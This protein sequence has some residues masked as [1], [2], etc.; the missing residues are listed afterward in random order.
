MGKG[1][2]NQTSSAGD[3]QALLDDYRGIDWYNEGWDIVPPIP[4]TV[5]DNKD[6]STSAADD[7]P[8]LII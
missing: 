1:I 4:V 8:I 7:L 2:G 5:D 3:I 6:E